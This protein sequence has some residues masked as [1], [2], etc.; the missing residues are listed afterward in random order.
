MKIQ[1]IGFVGIPVTDLKRARAFYEGVLDLPVRE[2]MAGGDWIEYDLGGDT[3]SITTAM[4]G[5]WMPSDQGT[6]AALEVEDFDAAIEKLKAAAIPFAMDAME[7]PVCR[8]AIV[9]DPDGNKLCIH[10]VKTDA[11]K[12][13]QG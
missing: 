12:A 8:L 6:C 11:E 7:T 5:M 13:Q 10:K 3:V 4:E 1:K 2:E 9:Q